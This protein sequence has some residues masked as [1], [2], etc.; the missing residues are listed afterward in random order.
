MPT[1][2]CLPIYATVAVSRSARRLPYK[3]RLFEA[4]DDLYLHEYAPMFV[5][6]EYI[7][8]LLRACVL[9]TPHL[10]F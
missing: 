3:H 10:S 1:H 6:T 7:K 9:F 5:F 2:L 4:A 8:S